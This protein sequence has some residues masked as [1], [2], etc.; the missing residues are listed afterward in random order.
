MASASQCLAIWPRVLCQA[1]E[2]WKEGVNLYRGALRGPVPFQ[3]AGGIGSE[4][5]GRGSGNFKRPGGQGPFE[6]QSFEKSVAS[7]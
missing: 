7:V 5:E 3:T 6:T 1:Q 2:E 4:M